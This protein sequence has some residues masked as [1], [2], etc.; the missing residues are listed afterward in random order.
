MNLIK[1]DG[2]IV[3]GA[4]VPEQLRTKEF[5]EAYAFYIQYMKENY[6]RWPTSTA[7]LMDFHKLK[8]LQD[9]GNCPIEVI[10]QTI[11]GRNKSFYPI[12]DF[13][14]PEE[15]KTDRQRHMEAFE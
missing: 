5:A 8:E 15:V 3:N 14:K 7:T 10:K 4:N 13:R 12:R 2:A 6:S 11:Q 9:K 1:K